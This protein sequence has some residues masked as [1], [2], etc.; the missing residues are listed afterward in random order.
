MTTWAP[1][2]HE[3]CTKVRSGHPLSLNIRDIRPFIRILWS[4][5]EGRR[6]CW[7]RSAKEPGL[8]VS[9]RTVQRAL[10][11]EGYT[12]CKACK[13]PVSFKEYQQDRLIYADQ[14]I[15]KPKQW[16]RSYR[17]S[18]ECTVDTFKRGSQWVTHLHSE[19]YHDDCIKHT[20]HSG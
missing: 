7:A 4:G 16:C 14:H 10:E 6:L 12:R 11:Q 8:G 19:S 20:F 5:W 13:R 3:W 2:P 17:Y 1:A 9:G 18:D 15:Q